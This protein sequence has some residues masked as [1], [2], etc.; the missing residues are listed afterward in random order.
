MIT[1]AQKR[2]LQAAARGER[3]T[4]AGSGPAYK[5]CAAQ[6]WINSS[7]ALTEEGL[8][9]LTQTGGLILRRVKIAVNLTH[10]QAAR[11]AAYAER[12]GMS[13][14]G[15]IRAWIDTLPDPE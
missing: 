3:A 8:A 5:S 1:E 10:E 4:F 15:A 11:L 14:P 7:G 13:A 6:G 9:M 12:I 2:V